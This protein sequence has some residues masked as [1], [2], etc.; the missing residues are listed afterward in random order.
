MSRNTF[1]VVRLCVL[2]FAF[3][4]LLAAPSG[5][6]AAS[7]PRV[8]PYDV[9]QSKK[10]I[11]LPALSSP[12]YVQLPLDAEVLG[13][14]MRDLRVYDGNDREVS[15][16]SVVHAPGTKVH[17]LS[18]TMSDLAQ[19]AGE[20]LF[21]LDLGAEPTLHNELTIQTDPTSFRRPVSVYA[22]E[23]KLGLDD[24]KWR[25]VTT[26]GYI[27]RAVDTKAGF[28]AGVSTVSYPASSARYLRVV[29][30]K[31]EGTITV[32]GASVAATSEESGSSSMTTAQASIEQNLEAKA[33]ELVFDLQS[34]V[35]TSRVTLTLGETFKAQDFHRRAVVSTSNDGANWQPV[36]QGYLYAVNLPNIS[37][38]S[39]SVAYPEVSSRY[40]RVVVMNDDN[41]PVI[42]GKS[43]SFESV[44]RS[45]VFKADP[46]S[47]YTL[48]YGNP[49]ATTPRYDVG[50][51]FDFVSA[52]SLPVAHLGTAQVNPKYVPPTPVEPPFS[53]RH[54][55][56]LGGTLAL[57]VIII[58]ALVARSFVKAAK[59]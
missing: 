28:D 3:C 47:V 51:I 34:A 35:P 42:W 16:Q 32:R 4:V 50:Q 41:A 5:H 25:A 27:A 57:L 8:A 56:V 49:S 7:L 40:I 54:P 59:K 24:A 44:S 48:Y 38:Q 13:N 6:V 17:E 58:G 39:M 53:E 52:N 29:I 31:G 19:R 23:Q 36:G 1:A 10:A 43:A 37:R 14:E 21:V 30:A 26:K 2:L 12:Q 46:A 11:A 22:S 33:T 45:L 20:T 55:Q 9:F 18:T 15:Y